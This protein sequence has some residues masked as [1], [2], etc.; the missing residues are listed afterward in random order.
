MN[1]LSTRLD[2]YVH[3][4]PMDNNNKNNNNNNNKQ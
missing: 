1:L 4:Q 3:Q 2:N